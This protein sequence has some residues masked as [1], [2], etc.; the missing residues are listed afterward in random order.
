MK[1]FVSDVE[2]IGRITRREDTINVWPR[3]NFKE[4]TV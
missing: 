1:V 2:T 4:G 3:Q